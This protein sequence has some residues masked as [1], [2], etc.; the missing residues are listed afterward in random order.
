MHTY[1]QI[2]IKGYV[3]TVYRKEMQM[4]YKNLNYAQLHSKSKACK[5]TLQ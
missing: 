5:L 2:Y 4:P 1:T 3:Q